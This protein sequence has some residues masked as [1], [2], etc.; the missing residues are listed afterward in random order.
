MVTQN[1]IVQVRF[2]AEIFIGI[3]CVPDELDI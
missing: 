1:F 2:A 3:G